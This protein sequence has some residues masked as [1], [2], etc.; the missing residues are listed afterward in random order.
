VWRAAKEK[1]C[2]RNGRNTHR[3]CKEEGEGER[4]KHEGGKEEES[5]KNGDIGISGS[6]GVLTTY[7][8]VPRVEKTLMTKAVKAA[9]SL[10]EPCTSGLSKRVEL[11][12]VLV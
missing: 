3:K 7:K 4:S 2:R 1:R 12:L 11:M 9:L 5:V 10:A 6:G 8:R